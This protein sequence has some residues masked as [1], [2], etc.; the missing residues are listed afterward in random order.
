MIAVV[1]SI[2]YLLRYQLSIAR[3]KM[4]PSQFVVLIGDIFVS[5]MRGESTSL[6]PAATLNKRCA[7]AS[8]QLTSRFPITAQNREKEALQGSP[9][10]AGFECF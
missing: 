7:A 6:L 8:L 3:K 2:T 10:E 1:S 5:L 9:A 4:C